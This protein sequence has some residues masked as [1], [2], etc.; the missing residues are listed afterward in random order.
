[1]KVLMP[2]RILERHVG[3]NTTYARSLAH[4]LRSRGITVEPMR[5]HAHPAATMASE[6]LQ[7]LT[8]RDGIMHYVADT[9][10]LVRTRGPSVVTVHGV[11]SRW[12]DGVRTGSQ[13]RVWR[14]RV[15]R[16]IASTDAVVTVSASSA[17]DIADVFGRSVDDIDVIP[18]GIDSAKFARP[19]I[20]SPEVRDRIPEH[21]LLYLGN[22][23][24]RKNIVALIDAMRSPAV[25]ALG[26][27]LVIAGKAAWNFDAEMHAIRSSPDVV[28]LGFVSDTD[29]TALM[30]RAALFVF[31]S[32]YEGFGFPVLEAMAAGAPVLTTTAGALRDVRGPA[33]TLLATEPDAIADGIV[34]ALTDETWRS[35][36]VDRGRDWASSFTWDVSVDAHLAVYKKVL[37]R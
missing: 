20:L 5:F 6:T 15:G 34:G 9:G 16:A 14:T 3:G 32:R 1:M 7:G 27:P 37:D 10:P 17:A 24:P 35:T 30:Q 22:I 26:L 11:A 36:V 25:R 31:P 2:G 28:H 13:E 23:E 33:R 29:R 4:G 19:E 18:H 8:R 12:L 21:F